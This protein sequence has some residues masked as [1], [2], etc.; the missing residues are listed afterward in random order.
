MKKF[1]TKRLTI[2]KIIGISLAGIMTA[3]I[4]PFTGLI[5]LNSKSTALAATDVSITNS[6][7][8]SYVSG[9][10]Y[11]PTN[12]TAKS[13]VT[14]DSVFFIGGRFDVD[15]FSDER[16]SLIDSWV[17][18]HDSLNISDELKTTLNSKLPVSG[19][20]DSIEGNDKSILAL[21][22][23]FKIENGVL[24]PI[25]N[26]Y[27]F[28]SAS[29][30][31]DAYGYYSATIFV[32]KT[33]NV[34][35]KIST[36]G[37]SDDAEEIDITP[38]SD[39]WE[40]KTVFFT[41]DSSKTVNINLSIVNNDDEE[42]AVYYDNLKVEKLTY[43]EFYDNTTGAT[44]DNT[45]YNTRNDKKTTSYLPFEQVSN[46]ILTSE[47]NGTDVTTSAE[48][49]VI[50]HY[51]SGSVSYKTNFGIY[52]KFSSFKNYRV[53]FWIK[54]EN[55]NSKFTIT[56]TGDM[57]GNP[58]KSSSTTISTATAGKFQEYV[59]YV[60][61]N[62]YEDVNFN[63][64]I[65]FTTEGKHTLGCIV[66]EKITADQYSS[67]SG[68]KLALNTNDVSANITNG[69]FTSYISAQTNS[70]KYFPSSWTYVTTGYKYMKD[71]TKPAELTT[72]DVNDVTVA[73]NKIVFDG[74]NYT[75]NANGDYYEYTN[76]DFVERIVKIDDMQFTFNE[77]EDEIYNNAYKCKVTNF[78]A[79]IENSE[80]NMS[81]EEIGLLVKNDLH[82]SSTN[83]SVTYMRSP[84]I[85]ISANTDS[86]ISFAALIE[87]NKEINIKLLDG[88]NKEI[89]AFTITGTGEVQTYRIYV[90]GGST[91][92]TYTLNFGLN[93]DSGEVRIANIG[94]YSATTFDTLNKKDSTSLVNTY[95]LDLSKNSIKSYS[96]NGYANG[97]YKATSLTS[98]SNSN[99]GTYGILDTLAASTYKTTYKDNLTSKDGD[100]NTKVI[101][102]DNMN[103]TD[104]TKLDLSNPYTLSSSSYYMITVYAKT[105]SMQSDSTFDIIFSASNENETIKKSFTNID[106]TTLNN[107]KSNGYQKYVLYVA[108]ST[109]EFENFNVEF[110]LKG[111]GTVLVDS[112]SVDSSTKSAF[113]SVTE[114]EFTITENLLSTTT[115]NT[116]E[117][118]EKEET[119]KETNTAMI[120]F[121]VFSSLLLVAAI[122]IAI[123]YLGAKRLPHH[124][125]AP[126][127]KKSN[128]RQG[129]GFV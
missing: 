62:S 112:V 31:T 46:V 110:D 2:R 18:N 71:N 80:D 84:E 118:E 29:F 1:T 93:N 125:R 30:T 119:K 115:T 86:F 87:N 128:P 67:A 96:Y 94:K 24:T 116:A 6:T 122:L 11:S 26:T 42:G 8:E 32:K 101:I 48:G 22:S 69:F 40:T 52:Q 44:N 65:N 107:E 10:T 117:D 91:A 55:A 100:T 121:I 23:S 72:I 50:D 27:T 51:N 104:N 123:I 7:F 106:T 81:D 5:K 73:D 28:T 25:A 88:S 78:T 47:E 57:N 49:V 38:T 45:I 13:N 82:L 75:Y 90:R 59:L 9:A 120:F 3:A 53:A 114:D 17:E 89:L 97:I 19:R 37:L 4:I 92:S 60:K 77:K 68:T 66:A 126:R 129:K 36:T 111:K 35:A 21:S 16:T 74:H 124:K 61:G 127:Q 70:T 34:S 15:T 14:D 20:K 58:S 85:S 63:L 39:N 64:E 76:G 56:L 41:I 99:V 12:W 108:T 54:S 109:T 79:K 113:T 98:L 103:E 33:G 95:I 102:I 43:Q 105:L 83:T